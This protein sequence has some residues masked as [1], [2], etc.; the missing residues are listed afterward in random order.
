MSIKIQCP[1]CGEPDT[2]PDSMLEKAARCNVCGGTFYILNAVVDAKDYK[3]PHKPVIR[4]QADENR[5]PK[6]EKLL[7]GLGLGIPAVVLI[8]FLVFWFGIR[9]TWETDNYQQIVELCEKVMDAT[10]QADDKTAEQAYGDLTALIED[11]PIE[12]DS[13]ANKVESVQSAMEPVLDR[14]EQTR[15][16]QKARQLAEKKRR[17]RQNNAQQPSDVLAPSPFAGGT[18]KGFSE[19]EL[20]RLYERLQSAGYSSEE[21]ILTV[22]DMLKYPDTRATARQWLR[23]N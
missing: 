7:L 8:T 3:S 2:L 6:S 19:Y 4:E 9:D 12:N 10:H 20:N 17:E 5:I 22:R 16:E 23:N 21:A 18:Y 1:D 11:R 13:L 15:R 14:L